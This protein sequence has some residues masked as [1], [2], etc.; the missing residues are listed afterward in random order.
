MK[1]TPRRPWTPERDKELRDLVLSGCSTETIAKA[2]NRTTFAVRRRAV[3]L[4]LPLSFSY[5]NRAG[6]DNGP[7]TTVIVTAGDLVTIQYMSGTTSPESGINLDANGCCTPSNTV[8]T[9]GVF[10][11]IYTTNPG[12]VLL[13]ELMG[14][15]AFNGVI[16]GTPFAIGDASLSL[17]A[18]ATA[19]EL[20]L[21]IND[22]VYGDNSGSLT[23]SVT[24]VASSVPEPSTWAMTIAGF[25]GLGLIAYR[26]QSKTALTAT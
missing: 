9:A 4:R 25:L 5:G 11:G 17:V 12:N 6:L 15:F 20:L 13:S 22:N 21:G 10:P 18:P 16:V 26:R 14:T 23:V 3:A 1:S 24:E 2:L 7:P 19:N 8:E